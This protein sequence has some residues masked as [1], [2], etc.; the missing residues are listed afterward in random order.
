MRAGSTGLGSKQLSFNIIFGSETKTGMPPTYPK[1]NSGMIIMH[2]KTYDPVIWK[3]WIGIERSDLL[4]L[5]KVVFSWKVMTC[6]LKWLF[7]RKLD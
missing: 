4:S 2:C 7:K 3:L 6:L 5:L 1:G